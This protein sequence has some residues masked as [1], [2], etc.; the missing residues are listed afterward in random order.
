MESKKNFTDPV[1][2]MNDVEGYLTKRE[3]KLLYNLAKEC[4]GKGV[5]VE[6]GSWKGKSTTC[7]GLGSKAGNNVRI[8]S[9]DPHTGSSEHKIRFGKIWTFK[10]FIKN[11]KKAGID[12]LVSPL[13]MSS[14]TAAKKWKG[15]KIE[16]LWIDGAHEYEFVELD[17][18]LWEPYLIDGGI[19]AF[20]DTLE[21]GPR[22]VVNKYIFKGK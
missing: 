15:K 9:I 13:V 4:R 6:I 3:G 19:I 20:H 18:L 14:K 8:F 1:K 11:I 7:L 2:I 5:I 12:E 17:Y 21:G 10:K 16:L 22:D